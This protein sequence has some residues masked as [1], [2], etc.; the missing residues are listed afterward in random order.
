MN[1]YYT[2][3]LL[4]KNH[5]NYLYFLPL[6]IL[7]F[8]SFTCI[9]SSFSHAYLYLTYIVFNI[10]YSVSSAQEDLLGLLGSPAPTQQQEQPQQQG[11]QQ[12]QQVKEEERDAIVVFIVIF[13][14]CIKNKILIL[15]I[16]FFMANIIFN[17]S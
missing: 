11:Q 4:A 8:L 14:F 5:Q 1:I 13:Y 3:K 17:L 2:V 7:F 15:M 12:Q 6:L 16:L 10:L 9:H